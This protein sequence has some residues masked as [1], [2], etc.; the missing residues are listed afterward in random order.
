MNIQQ[1][2]ELSTLSFPVLADMIADWE[3]REGVAAPQKL[4]FAAYIS[5]MRSG[6]SA[7]AGKIKCNALVAPVEY[8]RTMS[9]VLKYRNM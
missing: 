1:I 5:A 8:E 4:Y 2:S 3:E 9:F 6:L 7:E